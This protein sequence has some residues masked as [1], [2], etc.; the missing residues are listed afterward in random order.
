MKLNVLTDKKIPKKTGKT[1]YYKQINKVGR[2]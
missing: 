1:I 2:P